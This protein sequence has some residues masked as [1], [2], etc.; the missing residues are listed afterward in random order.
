MNIAFDIEVCEDGE[1][2]YA[3]L[4]TF[5]VQGRHGDEFGRFCSNQQVQ[6]APDFP[7][8]MGRID[9]MLE[10]RGLYHQQADHGPSRFFRDEGDGSEFLAEK[11]GRP[12][13][14]RSR[15]GRRSRQDE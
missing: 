10:R 7:R 15:C 14:A 3:T 8:L 13:A 11:T 2:N 5:S 4:Y 9:D 1:E 12:E 6:S